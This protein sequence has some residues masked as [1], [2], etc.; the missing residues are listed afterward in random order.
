MTI[1]C[2]TNGVNAQK[3][4]TV[5][6]KAV[7]DTVEF[8]GIYTT[9]KSGV[10]EKVDLKEKTSKADL[11]KK[12]WALFSGKDQYGNPIMNQNHQMTMIN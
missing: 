3:T 1:V 11:E 5:S 6:N 2:N 10:L 9:N 7:L 12:Y 8:M 4:L